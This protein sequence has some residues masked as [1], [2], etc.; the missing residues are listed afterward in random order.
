[1]NLRER[2]QEITPTATPATAAPTAFRATLRSHDDT[3]YARLKTDIHRKLL[4][5]VDLEVMSNLAEEPLRQELKTLVE[6]LLAEEGI[7][8]NALERKQ[9]VQD[10]QDEMLGLGPLEPLLADPT[11]SDIL[12]NGYRQVYVERAGRLELSGLRFA[13]NE[14]LLKIGR[15]HV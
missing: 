11:V 9:I 15:A 7:A 10:I 2:L 14:H 5:R 1:M 8:L 4:D 13:N 3:E 12:V 6:R